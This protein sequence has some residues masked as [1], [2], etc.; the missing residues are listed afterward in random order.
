VADRQPRYS[1]GLDGGCTARDRGADIWANSTAAQ[2]GAVNYSKSQPFGVWRGR[3]RPALCLLALQPGH[4]PTA[5][6]PQS[7]RNPTGNHPD[8]SRL[9][10][11]NSLEGMG[12]SAGATSVGCKPSATIAQRHQ[13]S[14][15]VN[16]VGCID[17]AESRASARAFPTPAFRRP[18]GV[19]CREG[20]W[21]AR[22]QT[23][24]IRP[25]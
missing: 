23:Q 4:K 11:A 22:Q 1:E 20:V 9:T 19:R 12:F 21:L 14:E 13:R 17:R 5:I 2:K 16:A 3:R 25:V 7:P 8:S 18:A 10:L 15:H 6:P 24:S